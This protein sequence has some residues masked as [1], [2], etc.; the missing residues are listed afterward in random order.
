[1]SQGM[2]PTPAGRRLLAAAAELFYAQGIN[3]V[4]VATI[5]EAANVTKKTLYDC[6]GSKDGIVVAYLTQRHQ[7]WRRALETRLSADEPSPLMVFDSYLDILRREPGVNGCGFINAAAD[8][9]AGHR[10]M[11]VIRDH[12]AEVRRQIDALLP[13]RYGTA[14]ASARETIVTHLFYLLEGGTAEAGLLGSLKPLE[15][16]RRITQS[17]LTL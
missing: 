14:S 7:D 11:K 17:L 15:D 6:F 12:K 2:P 4:G 3:A 9:P 5:A 8:L 16:S 10:A 1:M 13:S